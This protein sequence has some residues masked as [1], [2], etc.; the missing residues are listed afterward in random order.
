MMLD[1]RVMVFK[2]LY[3]TP[4]PFAQNSYYPE[5][6][7]KK[8]FRSFVAGT[9]TFPGAERLGSTAENKQG[10]IITKFTIAGSGVVVA[11]VSL[12]K[13]ELLHISQSYFNNN[14]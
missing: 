1:R 6:Y 12:A 7:T 5:N 9:H 10:G 3:K 4:E 8:P 13:A 11:I 2:I 14:R